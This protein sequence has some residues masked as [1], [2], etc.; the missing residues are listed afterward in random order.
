MRDVRPQQHREDRPAGD[1]LMKLIFGRKINLE[2]YWP[3]F[4]PTDTKKYYIPI[5]VMGIVRGFND[6]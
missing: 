3:K 2:L 4:Y 1:D 6:N 5:N